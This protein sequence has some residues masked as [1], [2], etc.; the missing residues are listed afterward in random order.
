M[1][2]ELHAI[3]APIFTARLKSLVHLLKI[4]EAEGPARGLSEE[5]LLGARLAPDM[6]ELKR[7]VQIATDHAK[8]AMARLAGLDVPSFPDN[9]Q[10]FA[11]LYARIDKTLAFVASVQA[12]SV[13]GREETIVTLKLRQ[14]T[15]ELT[16][17]DYLQGFALPNFYFHLT[18]AYDILRHLGMPVGKRDFLW[19]E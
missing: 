13:N 6:F 3:S 12:T 2:I 1:T 7:Q 16:A 4:G 5:A 14:E 8:G 11:E 18:T 10:T 9:E 19:R 17:I 15:M